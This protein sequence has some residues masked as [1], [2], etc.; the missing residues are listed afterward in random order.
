MAEDIPPPFREK[1]LYDTWIRKTEVDLQE[2]ITA[3]EDAS[4][5][6]Q[7][8]STIEARTYARLLTWYAEIVIRRERIDNSRSRRNAQNTLD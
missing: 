8:S 6:H 7:D 4:W 1:M 2:A 5:H 3:A